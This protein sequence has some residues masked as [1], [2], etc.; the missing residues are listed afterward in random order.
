VG[1]AAGKGGAGQSGAAGK[2]GAGQ[3]GAGMAGTGGAGMAGTGGAGAGGDSGAGQGGAGGAGMSGGAGGG[4]NLLRIGI[5]G[6]PG[7]N[8]SSNFQAW[9][10]ALGTSAE[11]VGTAPADAFDDALLSKYDV[12]ILD[13]L[14]R[15]YTAGEASA[16]QKWVLGGGGFVSMTGYT[17]SPSDFRANAL[18]TPFGLAYGG[19]LISGPVTSFMPH[20]VTAGL[21]SVTFAGGYAIQQTAVVGVNTTVIAT[22]GSDPVGEALLSGGGR[23]IVWGD[24]WIEFDSEWST[25]PEIKQLW[26]NALTWVTP[27]AHCALKP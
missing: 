23:G 16:L 22:I 15:E 27:H 13:Q 5:I 24:E 9:L 3:G 1:A 26:V 25:M 19:P 8:P 14:V 6:A 20:P 21:T 7:S 12:I 17:N 2:G 4:C 18:L 10:Q 11:R